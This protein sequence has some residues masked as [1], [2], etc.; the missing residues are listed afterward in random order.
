VLGFMYTAGAVLVRGA[1]VRSN[2]S[3]ARDSLL[4]SKYGWDEATGAIV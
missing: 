1:Q 4:S 2:S 3:S